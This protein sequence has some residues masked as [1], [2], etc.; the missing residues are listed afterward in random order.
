MSKTLSATILVL[1]IPSV[2]LPKLLQR[3]SSAAKNGEKKNGGLTG[4]LPDKCVQLYELGDKVLLKRRKCAH[5]AC[6]GLRLNT[7]ALV[8]MRQHR[9]STLTEEQCEVLL[10]WTP[11][12]CQ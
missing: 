9:A 12:K 5:S 10:S 2:A 8:S 3:S 11:L 4:Q 1:L 6:H 7:S